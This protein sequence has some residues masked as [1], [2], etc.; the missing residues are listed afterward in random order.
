MINLPKS[1]LIGEARN[2]EILSSATTYLYRETEA[3]SLQAH[4]FFPHEFDYER[5]RKPAIFFF[6]GGLW[7][8]SAPAQFVPHC[9]HFASRGMVAATLE[10]RTKVLFDGT[11]EDA[12]S[13][14]KAALSFFKANAES[15]GIDASQIVAG[16][17]SAGAN[18]LLSATLHPHDPE[19][20]PEP[21]PRALILFGPISDTSPSGIGNEKFRTPRDGKLQSP[22]R[23]LPR[24][25]LPPCLIFHAKMDRVVPFEL[26]QRFAKK[27][28]KRRNRCDLMEFERAGHTFFNYNSDQKNYEITLRSADHFLVE[29]GILEPDPLADVL[30]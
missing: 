25:G 6:H 2:Q 3:G 11:P 29:L 24:K 22:L 26:S 14:A 9:H 20:G 16:G 23:Y 7:D 15:M 30:H 17:A 8:I 28:R 10:Y 12:I 1:P 13:D 4:F 19:K 21:S 27:Y 18:A 5:D